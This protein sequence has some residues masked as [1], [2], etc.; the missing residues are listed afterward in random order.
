MPAIDLSPIT[1]YRR[2]IIAQILWAI[3]EVGPFKDEDGKA[4]APLIESLNQRGINFTGSYISGLLKDLE[5]HR[6][7]KRLVKRNIS[8]KRC[9]SIELA[10][11]VTDPGF[12]PNPFEDA[13]PE[14]LDVAEV[15]ETEEPEEPEIVVEDAH[16]LVAQEDEIEDIFVPGTALE[17]VEDDEVR[18]QDSPEDLILYA[19]SMLS[20][21][22]K[23]L[24]VQRSINVAATLDAHV[25]ALLEE[26]NTL[27][28]QVDTAQRERDDAVAQ[29]DALLR[30]KAVMKRT[31]LVKSA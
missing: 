28:R 10:V 1:E 25:P 31:Q 5:S 29:R 26:I 13:E 12:P 18:D 14:V 17:R 6:Y 9:Y 23:G 16:E 4:T 24:T 20:D 11:D 19:I 8:G 7:G 3:H 30:H 21:A 2:T 27:R 22:V 15:E